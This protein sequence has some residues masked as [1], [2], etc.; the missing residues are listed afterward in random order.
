MVTS[1]E[2]E[3]ST[4]L[5]I[6]KPPLSINGRFY[7]IYS[8]EKIKLRPCGSKVLNL[9]LKIKLPDGIQGIIGLLHAFIQQ[10]LT[11]ENSKHITPQTWEEP[12]KLQY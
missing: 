9:Q 5:Q 1:R 6:Q 3:I 8:P 12:V 2:I 7:R 11:I 10:S 4:G